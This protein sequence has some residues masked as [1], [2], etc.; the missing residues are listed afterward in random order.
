MAVKPIIFIITF[1]SLVDG[2]FE[3]LISLLYVIITKLLLT[4]IVN[5]RCPWPISLPLSP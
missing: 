1:S 2:S 5:K 4:L 3:S